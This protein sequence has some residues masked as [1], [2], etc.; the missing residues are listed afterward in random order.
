MI[1]SRWSCLTSCQILVFLDQ[2]AKIFFN[3]EF[4][5]GFFFLSFYTQARAIENMTLILYRWY[6][7]AWDRQH[8]LLLLIKYVM[9]GKMWR[10]GDKGNFLRDEKR[11]H[12]FLKVK[13][14]ELS[15]FKTP[16][17][18]ILGQEHSNCMKLSEYVGA[19]VE[20]LW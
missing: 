11:M 9:K 17:K 5:A 13:S 3:L 8:L 16:K 19:G 7:D 15:I 1:T 12:N 10:L 2:S 14:A 4:Q 18:S 6:N 20:R